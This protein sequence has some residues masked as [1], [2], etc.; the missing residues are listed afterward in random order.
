MFYKQ[1]FEDCM[2]TFDEVLTKLR[3]R[4]YNISTEQEVKIEVVK[5]EIKRVMEDRSISAKELE[6]LYFQQYLKLR[7]IFDTIGNDTYLESKFIFLMGSINMLFTL[8]IL[9]RKRNET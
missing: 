9:G 6:D 8:E 5:E 3:D 7:N 1:E 4:K 2:D